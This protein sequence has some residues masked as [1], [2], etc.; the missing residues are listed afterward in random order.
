MKGSIAEIETM[1]RAALIAV[2]DEVFG[3]PV[4]KRLSSPFLRRF[5]AFEMQ[6]GERGGIPKGFA[7]KLDK[8]ARN[9]SSAMS[10]ALKTGG[11]LVREWNGTTHVVDVVEDGFLW[12]DQRFASLSA[13]ARAITGARWSG[14]RFFGLRQSR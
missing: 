5:L 10:P 13:I 3:T 6:A 11:R 12:S 7:A 4:P 1:D 14:P 2:W 9:D 8:A